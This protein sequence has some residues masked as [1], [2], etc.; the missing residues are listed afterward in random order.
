LDRR[1][2]A[3]QYT[4]DAAVL[5]LGWKGSQRKVNCMAGFNHCV[6]A[7]PNWEKWGKLTLDEASS[8]IKEIIL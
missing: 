8:L 6:R 2:D 1:G 7:F 3:R 4:A 5:S